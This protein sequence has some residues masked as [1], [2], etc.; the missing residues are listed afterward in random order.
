M[1]EINYTLC[2]DDELVSLLKMGDKLA[3]ETIYD[4]F[5]GVLY[6]HAF[7]ILQ[8]KEEAKDILQ[9]IFSRLW[10]KR[11]TIAFSYGLS[12]YLYASVRNGI[13]DLIAHRKVAQKYLTSLS[14]FVQVDK[15]ETDHLIR[16][17]QLTEMIERE[18]SAL[19]PKMKEVFEM[20]RRTHLSHR[21]IAT[22]LDISEKTVKKQVNN[23]LKVL[24]NKLGIYAFLFF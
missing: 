5:K 19:P 22:E 1:S 2:S 13:F 21:E 24:R 17:R 10:T 9:E 14:D 20:S 6:I 11:E 12:A 15:Y 8:D 4:R 7:R 18:I 3:F 16:E 23:A